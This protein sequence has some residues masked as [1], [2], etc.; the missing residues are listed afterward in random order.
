MLCTIYPTVLVLVIA[1]YFNCT[2]TELLVYLSVDF[3]SVN[4]RSSMLLC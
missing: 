2:N 1:V 4:V 3:D